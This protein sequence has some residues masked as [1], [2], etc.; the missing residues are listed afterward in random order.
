MKFYAVK[1]G[2]QTGVFSDPWEQ[3]KTLVDKFPGAIYKGFSSYDEAQKWFHN[4]EMASTTSPTLAVTPETV[5]IPFTPALPPSSTFTTPPTISLMPPVT[6]KGVVVYT[7]G[8][9]MKKKGGY[10]VVIVYPNGTHTCHRGHVPF[11]PCTN[12][13]A[14]LYAVKIAMILVNEPTF[15]LYTDSK[16]SIGCLQDWLANWRRNGWRD[17]HGQPVK[18]RELIESIDSTRGGR[19][20]TFE[21]V[22]GHDGNVFNEICDRLAKEGVGM[23]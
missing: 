7:D 14:E 17:V 21:W 2:R 3:V 16:Y 5:T 22:K 11:D 18:N 1:K 13:I 10:G 6:Q 9:C 12:N 4:E 20:I 23:E 8:S 19:T 15:T